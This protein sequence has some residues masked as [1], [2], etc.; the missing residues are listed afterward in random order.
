M[1]PALRHNLAAL[2]AGY[3]LFMIGLSFASPSTILPAC[4]AHLGAPNVVIGAIPAVM[5]LGWLLWCGTRATHDG[6]LPDPSTPCRVDTKVATEGPTRG[7][8]ECLKSY[9]SW[10]T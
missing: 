1:R 5:T 8:P 2:G 9:Q 7:L 3:A 10:R 4:A 6:A